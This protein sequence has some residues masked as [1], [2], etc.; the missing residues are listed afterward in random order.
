MDKKMF[1]KAVKLYSQMNCKKAIESEK[2][3]IWI[4]K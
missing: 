2:D 1:W 3:R 4:S